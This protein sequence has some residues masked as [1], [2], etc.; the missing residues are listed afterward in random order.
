M[1]CAPEISF[2]AQSL[3][4]SNGYVLAL[5]GKQ[6]GPDVNNENRHLSKETQ[7][8]SS[9]IYINSFFALAPPVAPTTGQSVNSSAAAQQWERPGGKDN[10]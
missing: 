2:G 8:A 6:Y 10:D 7:T 9:N 4:K 3:A 1:N 5:E